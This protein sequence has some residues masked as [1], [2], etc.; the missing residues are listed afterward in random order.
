MS[1]YFYRLTVT[2]VNIQWNIP[3]I[4][5]QNYLLTVGIF[6]I[7]TIDTGFAVVNIPYG[8]YSFDELANELEAQIR[9][10]FSGT[11]YAVPNLTVTWK[12]QAGTAGNGFVFETNDVTALITFSSTFPPG[13]TGINPRPAF[14]REATILAGTNLNNAL[15]SMYK[16][17]TMLGITNILVAKFSSYLAALPSY[18]TLIYTSYVDVISNKLSQF[19]RVKDSE[20]SWSP[21]TS[22]IT[23]IYMTNQGTITSPQV[24]Y[25]DITGSPPVQLVDFAEYGVG[26]RP[27]ILNYTPTT[28]KNI[29]WSPDQ[30]IV[31]F[32]IRVVDEFGDLLPWTLETVGKQ[33]N[34]P[35]VAQEVFEFQLTVLCSE[36]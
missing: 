5:S 16:L 18:P 35:V 32:D 30:S 13:Y 6:I 12:Q 33:L 21:D 7:P 20:T 15:R 8:Y 25:T 1:G 22:V 4:C 19:M 34:N 24:V 2:D 17:Y 27:F 9:Y 26:S 11:I 29:K 31:D 36:T 23:R 3:T 10:V 14:P 28:P